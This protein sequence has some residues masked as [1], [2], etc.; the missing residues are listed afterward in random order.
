VALEPRQ[1]P[2]Q[3]MLV[4]RLTPSGHINRAPVVAGRRGFPGVEFEQPNMHDRLFCN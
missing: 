2:G 4:E 1:C 3:L